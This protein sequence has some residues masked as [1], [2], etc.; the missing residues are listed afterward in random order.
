[1][2]EACLSIVSAVSF[3]SAQ[4]FI[5]TK[6]HCR[7]TRERGRMKTEKR[8]CKSHG[9]RSQ[10]LPFIRLQCAT[11][12]YQFTTCAH[13]YWQLAPV[14]METRRQRGRDLT[15]ELFTQQHHTDTHDAPHT[16]HTR[17]HRDTH[18]RHDI[19]NLWA[20]A[21]FIS[22]WCYLSQLNSIILTFAMCKT[23]NNW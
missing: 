3:I 4:L 23:D 16:M 14:P 19:I 6:K 20:Q 18:Q 12:S 17:T 10:D 7:S 5:M 9:E 1:M 21:D 2:P 15:L 13:T 11:K 22:V 8:K